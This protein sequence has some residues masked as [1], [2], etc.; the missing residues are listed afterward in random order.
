MRKK[1]WLG[2]LF[3]LLI[4]V[5]LTLWIGYLVLQ[6]VSREQNFVISFCENK[7][8]IYDLDKEC[9]KDNK[10]CKSLG[11]VNCSNPSTYMLSRLAS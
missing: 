6:G 11:L 9:G 4:G 1:G 7:T 2:S 8:G 5:T 3:V 10:V